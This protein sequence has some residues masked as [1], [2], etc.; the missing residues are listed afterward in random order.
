[1]AFSIIK[2]TFRRIILIGAVIISIIFLSCPASADTI[3]L[4]SGGYWKGII[5]RSDG[6][7]VRIYF[8][9]GYL[10]VARETSSR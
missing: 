4:R 9:G 2:F 3:N 8:N 10:N 6:D 1:M 7:S 5:R